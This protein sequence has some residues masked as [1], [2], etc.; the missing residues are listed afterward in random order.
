MKEQE[1]IRKAVQK[2]F[3]A[4]NILV[5]MTSAKKYYDKIDALAEI[6]QQLHMSIDKK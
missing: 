6:A 4:R 3:D 5:S 2:I 1:E